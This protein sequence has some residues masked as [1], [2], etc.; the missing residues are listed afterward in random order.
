VFGG[1][2]NVPVGLGLDIITEHLAARRLQVLVNPMQGTGGAVKCAV[3]A[4]GQGA[5]D[6][7]LVLFAELVILQVFEFT[8][9]RIKCPKHPVGKIGYTA[10][11]QIIVLVPA[12]RGKSMKFLPE[13]LVLPEIQHPAVQS[14]FLFL[15]IIRYFPD[16]DLWLWHLHKSGSLMIYMVYR[17]QY[18][19]LVVTGPGPSVGYKKGPLSSLT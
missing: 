5:M 4:E 3:R 2:A 11:K 14:H 10:I 1:G 12:E 13:L 19:Q 8:G 7:D 17:P 6:L 15:D 16:D 9:G 18:G